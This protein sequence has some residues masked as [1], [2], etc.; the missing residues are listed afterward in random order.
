MIADQTFEQLLE[1]GVAS[2]R[3]NLDWHGD[4][5]QAMAK[6]ARGVARFTARKESEW[7]NGMRATFFEGVPPRRGLPRLL[8]PLL[9]AVV[10]VPEAVTFDT[11]LRDA[12]RRFA[13]KAKAPELYTPFTNIGV[14]YLYGGCG[15]TVGGPAHVP[16]HTDP[17][18]EK[19]FVVA[20]TVAGPPNEIGVV[21]LFA[22]AD[23]C[24]ARGIQQVPHQASA[25]TSRISYTFA[26]LQY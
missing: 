17:A 13:K 9:S 10:W 11:E 14:N 21:S 4:Q 19:G 26:N 8:A 23:L 22:C 2:E 18:E 20:V 1:E 16:E 5:L 7:V 25:I 3:L 6:R 24:A 12:A 15:I